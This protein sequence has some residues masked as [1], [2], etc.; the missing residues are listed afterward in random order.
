MSAKPATARMPLWGHLLCAAAT[1]AALA[2]SFWQHQ[3]ALEKQQ[4][5]EAAEASLAQQPLS[6][7]ELVS[8]PPPQL[9]WR[10]A[11]LTGR[12]DAS[13]QFLL[14]NR[15]W[16]GQ[17]GFHVLVPLQ[18]RED[19]WIL[20]N[21][22]FLDSTGDRSALRP[23]PP[24]SG[25][26]TVSGQLAAPAREALRLQGPAVDGMIWRSID[27]A[28]WQQRT[29]RPV[30]PVV[31]VVDSDPQ[32]ASVAGTPD[33]RAATSRGYRLQWLLLAAVVIAGWLRVTRVLRR[34]S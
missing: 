11:S 23:P 6:L 21:R 1:A 22:G 7:A 28:L 32:L 19:L 25:A 9:R 5:Q 2:A 17:P 8:L 15:V 16:Q 12:Y 33:F 10:R 29:G 31:L 34:E 18:V 14:D 4:L 20:V 13:G 30:L 3:R 26:I 27:L 24:P